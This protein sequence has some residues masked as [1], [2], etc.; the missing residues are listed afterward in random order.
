MAMSFWALGLLC[1]GVLVLAGVVGLVIW[2][3]SPP[4]RK[5]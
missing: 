2:I 4:E 3:V 1:V 5:D